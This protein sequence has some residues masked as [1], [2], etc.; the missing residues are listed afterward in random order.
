VN[1]V[2]CFFPKACWHPLAVAAAAFFGLE[3]ANGSAFP[4]RALHAAV[5]TGNDMIVWG[6]DRTGGYLN[7]GALY[8]PVANYWT[9]VSLSGAAAGRDSFTAVWTGSDMIVW[10]GWGSLGASTGPLNTGGNYVPMTD[11]WTATTTSSAP[12][13]RYNHT[14]VWTGNAMIIWGGYSFATFTALNDGGRYNPLTDSWTNTTTTGAPAAR[15]THAAVWTGNEMIVWGGSGASGYL[16]DGGRYNPVSNSWTAVTNT[17][18]PAAR[19]FAKA[20]WTGNE[21]IVWGGYNGS[22]LN[23]GGRYNPTNNTWTMVTNTGAPSPRYAHTAVWTGSKMIIWGGNNGSIP[24][25]DGAIY[26]PVSNTWTPVST[27]GAPSARYYHTAVWTGTEMIVWG[28]SSGSL[29]NDG[30]RYNPATDT[31]TPLPASTACTS[32]FPDDFGCRETI[33]GDNAS[34]A[35][36]NVGATKETGEPSHGGDA[37]G[38]SLWWDWVAPY[39]GGVTLT[40]AGSD[41]V[42]TLGVYTGTN[43]VT[44]TNVASDGRGSVPGSVTFAATGG[45]DY[46]IAVDGYGGATGNIL[47]T[48]TLRAQPANDNFSNR[49]SIATGSVIA[50]QNQGAT[51]EPGETNH[52]GIVGGKSVWWSWTAPSNCSALVN[53]EGSDFDTVVGVY[54]GN[55]LA[56]L[57]LVGA[58]DDYAG[59][60]SLAGFQAT[61]GV[62]YQIAVDGN[63]RVG[64]NI[65]LQVL[66]FPNPP[67]DNFANATVLAGTSISVTASN[68]FAAT[69]EPG[70]PGMYGSVWWQWQAPASGGISID[71]SGGDFS[72]GVVVY[73]GSSVS[74]LTQVA[75]NSVGN[76]LF[77]AVA[78]TTYDIALTG[79]IGQLKLNL[80]FSPSPPNDDFANRALLGMGTSSAV[81]SN[82]GATHEFFS[83]E[84]Y[85]S[86]VGSLFPL[87]PLPNLA[88]KDVWWSWTGSDPLPVTISTVSSNFISTIAIY[89]G[90]SLANLTLVA[91]HSGTSPTNDLSFNFVP[92]TNYNIVV[93]GN[94]GAEG[95]FTLYATQTTAPLNNNFANRFVLSG[96]NVFTTGRNTRASRETGE[97]NH[98]GVAGVGSVWWSWT[99]PGAGRLFVTTAGSSFAPL[100]ALY[101]GTSV[102]GLTSNASGY[103]TSCPYISCLDFDITPTS[104]QTYQIAVDG[105]SGAPPN[106]GSIN[107]ALAFV[108]KPAND[109]FNSRQP[110]TG[111][112]LVVTNSVIA[113]S[114]EPGEVVAGYASGLR[115]VWYSWTAP[116]NLGGTA[117]GVTIRV[118]GINVNGTTNDPL[119]DVFQGNSLATLTEVP[120]VNKMFA[121]IR[122]ITFT[123]QAGATY[124]IAVAG[125][126]STGAG[127][128]SSF[129]ER[130][131]A[132]PADPLSETGTF[133]LHLNYSTLA[134]RVTN[135]LPTVIGMGSGTNFVE[136]GAQV[137]NFGA[138]PSG[139]VRVRMLAMGYG[140]IANDESE[141]SFSPVGGAG[142]PSGNAVTIPVNGKGGAV[143]AVLEEQVGGD[144]FFRDSSLVCSPGLF[145]DIG[146]INFP[147]GAVISGGGVA[148]LEPGLAGQC[149]CPAKLINVLINGP[150]TVFEGSSAAYTGT[151]F[152]D[153]GSAPNFT[154][155]IWSTSDTNK[156][157]ITTNGILTAG[158]VTADTPI[159]VTSYYSYLGTQSSTNKPVTILNLP[160]PTL[161]SLPSLSNGAFQF[162]LQGVP[163]RQHI[164]EAATNLDPPVVWSNLLTN[165]TGQNGSLIFT[166]PTVTNLSRRFYRAREN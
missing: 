154:N 135:V 14:A 72:P 63:N 40:T 90:T 80:N 24:L 120:M 121:N 51:V 94:S 161:T 55:S 138:D 22:S 9:A 60:T 37:G 104:P 151:A 122:Q 113:A 79:G 30:G 97:P 75:D 163:G 115:T 148:L 144:W 105:A 53:T 96:T 160:P 6:G 35:A 70:E 91:A 93:D 98:A 127:Y 58:S 137:V 164:I 8:D 18:A 31:W 28:G 88:G 34:V 78:G 66:T 128:K 165:V 114:Q 81:G 11:S 102:S 73:T 20:V 92:G 106:E 41:F 69:L 145:G 13:A 162:S 64:G 150:A 147:C 4:A 126:Q 61:V 7:D 103:A 33:S 71:T 99:S 56:G 108:P 132:V 131:S 158:S 26:N 123:A 48:L 83:N 49:I 125:G 118:T 117:G 107:L 77:K 141:G 100:L 133:L 136:A 82:I 153:N 5:W 86:T 85:S 46:K 95:D 45:V 19:S 140:V 21:M 155:S 109:D 42:T 139:P 129:A 89:T 59:V 159:S 68:T 16:N 32:G 1:A 166:D 110:L 87:L 142:L 29:L 67:N 76:V 156:F 52:A 36:N 39:S 27:I 84:L 25:N 17:G 47:L 101:Q 65:T 12:S 130:T 3:S 38:H 143:L 146:V 57:V 54:T 15:F 149:F 50:A 2:D 134:L 43:V 74:S 111:S 10:G 62:T 119:V 157:P 152:F 112:F 124:Q 116:T 23:D 44:L